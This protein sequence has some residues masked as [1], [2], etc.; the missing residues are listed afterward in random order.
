MVEILGYKFPEGLY[1]S[2]D[3]I[4]VK[5]ENGSVRMGITDF[6]QQMAGDIVFI[7]LSPVG[8]G[9]KSGKAFGTMETGKWVGPL[10]SPLTGKIVERNEELSEHPEY[11]NEDPY[12]KG[13]MV[14]LEPEN[15]D[16]EIKQ[17][18]SKPEEIEPWLKAEIE[19]IEK[20]KK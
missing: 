14:V 17:L 11:V 10:K 4:W 12:G 20:E 16:E 1:Y 18:M 13:W 3:H 7:R 5:V 15:L 6:A 2:K 19:K 9:V 8:K